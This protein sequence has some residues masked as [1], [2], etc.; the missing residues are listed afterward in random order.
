MAMS[1]AQIATIL[2]N[3]A[4]VADPVLDILARSDPFD[5]KRRTFG[6]RW[7]DV[8]PVSVAD[9]AATALDVADWPGTASWEK[10]STRERADWWVTRIGSLSTVA[11]AFP[12]IFGAWT[13]KLPIGDALG[14]ASQALTVL[15]VGREYGVISRD[16]QIAMLGSVLFGRD[17]DGSHLTHAQPQ[18]FPQSGGR[19]LLAVF[20]GLWRIARWLR[21]LQKAL[22]ARPQSPSFFRRLAW[23][24]LLGAPATY[25][26]ERVAL[27]R[28]VTS[29]Q[30]WIAENPAAV[31]D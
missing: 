17:V 7:W 30:E 19:L 18:E 12:G 9:A 29:A 28:A 13:K 21:D 3:T 25:V 2:D 8:I 4:A 6:R 24:P 23:I 27:R 26:G 10:L 14:A 20:K 31:V 16:H 11:V 5:L 22:A 1:D 15:A